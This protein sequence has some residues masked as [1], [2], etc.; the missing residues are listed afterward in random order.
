MTADNP[1]WK[2][3]EG[4]V[5]ALLDSDAYDA[6]VTLVIE[7]LGPDVLDYFRTALQEDEAQ[8]ALQYW[9][10]EVWRFLRQFR[11]EG[12]LRG[13]AYQVAR[14]SMYRILRRGYRTRE[15]HL[16]SSAISRVGPMVGAS[17]G[18]TA[19]QQRGLEMLRANLDPEDQELLTLRID[20]ELEWE[21]IAGVLDSTAVVLRK[22]YERLTK[23]LV[24]MARDRGLID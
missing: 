10:Q 22:R 23:R 8:D 9:S 15:E 14:R 19:E 11:W 2:E 3:L 4:R 6:A 5:R 12:S 20:R 16:S 13:W 17:R 21:E 7:V 24:Q 18:S 1:R